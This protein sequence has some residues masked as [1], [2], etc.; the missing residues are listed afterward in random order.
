MILWD[1]GLGFFNGSSGFGKW[2]DVGHSSGGSDGHCLLGLGKLIS[3]SGRGDG[4]G[5]RGSVDGGFGFDAVGGGDLGC[6]CRDRCGQGS[7]SR[8]GPCCNDDRCRCGR[9]RSFDPCTSE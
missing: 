5:G 6:G 4:F 7:G 9:N 3:H 1:A 2:I 8:P